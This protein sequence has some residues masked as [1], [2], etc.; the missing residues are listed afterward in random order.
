MIKYC[1]PQYKRLSEQYNV[2]R[3]RRDLITWLNNVKPGDF[4]HMPIKQLYAIFY[5]RLA[6][7]RGV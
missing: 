3:N 5:K 4:N 7:L 6:Q 1:M 2:P